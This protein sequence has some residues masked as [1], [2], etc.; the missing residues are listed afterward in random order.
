MLGSPSLPSICLPSTH[1]Q[2]YRT[3]LAFETNWEAELVCAEYTAFLPT[4]LMPRLRKESDSSRVGY[5][6]SQEFVTRPITEASRGNF[7]CLAG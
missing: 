3:T 7:K 5:V 4:S 1:K 6:G 2:T